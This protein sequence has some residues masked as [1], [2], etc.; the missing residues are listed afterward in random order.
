MYMHLHVLPCTAS[1][2]YSM[3]SNLE[4]ASE[5]LEVEVGGPMEA[6][7]PVDGVRRRA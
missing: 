5:K 1:E 4:A 6:H 7:V 2:Y 3:N